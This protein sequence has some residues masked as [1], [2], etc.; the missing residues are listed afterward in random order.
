MALKPKA[1]DKNLETT[2]ILFNGRLDKQLCYVNN[3]IFYMSAYSL[4]R[5]II[6]A[7]LLDS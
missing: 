4:S 5:A 6:S 1:N 7:C 2:Q 3:E